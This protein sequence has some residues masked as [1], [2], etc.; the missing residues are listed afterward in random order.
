MTEKAFFD[1]ASW[2][3]P[4]RKAQDLSD[5][6]QKGTS[7]ST[8]LTSSYPWFRLFNA[9]KCPRLTTYNSPF[10]CSPPRRRPYTVNSLP[11]NLTAEPLKKFQTHGKAEIA[12][13]FAR[14]FKLAEH[15]AYVKKT[16][17]NIAVGTPGRIRGLVDA[18]DG[19]LKLEKLR[20]LIVDANYMDGKKRTIFDIP[21]TMRDLF[22][23]FVHSEVKKRIAEGKLRVVF[24]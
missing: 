7:S 2:E 10:P 9:Y 14:H 1:T 16:H 23:V 19:V 8:K 21:E 15:I 3:N 6:L 24:Y 11:Q 18:E 20:Y 13:L 17:M 22:G 5:F 4:E 12:K